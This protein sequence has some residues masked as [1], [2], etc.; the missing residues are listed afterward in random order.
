MKI[1]I[2]I[3]S[4]FALIFGLEVE[5]VAGPVLLGSFTQNSSFGASVVS[6]QANFSMYYGDETTEDEDSHIF[7]DLFVSSSDVGE[8][9]FATAGFDKF[10]EYLTNGSNDSLMF[11]VK[12][13]PGGG[14]GMGLWESAFG[15]SPDFQGYTVT[16]IGLTINSLTFESPGRNP[17][18]DGNWT[19][20]SYNVTF[21]I[22]GPSP[23]AI[24]IKPGSD[25]NAINLTSKGSVP[26]A[27]LTTAEFDASTVDP[28]TVK[29]ADAS[30]LKW[31]MTDVDFD[32]DI[33]VLLFFNTQ[34]LNLDETSTE[35]TLT[36]KTDAG[37]DI[38][39]TDSVSIVPKGKE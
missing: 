15:A 22:Y 35:G 38:I 31:K 30:P 24:D 37:I 1:L 27:I 4:A 33:D 20:C 8:E 3:A 11:W 2:I 21:K 10:V 12:F 19:D 5:G 36:G 18:G 25:P 39:G 13:P 17:S 16:A 26:V 6:S 9:F 23:V 14:A 29:F 28:T 34:A 7:S 32:G